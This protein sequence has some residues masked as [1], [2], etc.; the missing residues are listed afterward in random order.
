MALVSR[1]S[2]FAASLAVA[3]LFVLLWQAVST[4][5]LVSPLFLPSPNR[6]Y[7]ALVRGLVQGPALAATLETVQ[8]MFYGWLVASLLGIGIGAAIG[9]SER[10]R[11][12]LSPLLEALRPLPASALFPIVIALFGLSEPTF[13]L[14]I[15]FGAVWPMLL[16][17]AHG[18]ATVEPTLRDVARALNMT[19][20]DVVRKIALP[21]AVPE[22]VAAMRLG[23]TIALILAVVGEM[24]TGCPGLGRWL[25]A[26]ARAYRSAD[27]FAGVVL[28]G[29]I[30]Y[31]SSTLLGLAE[32]RLLRW[33]AQVR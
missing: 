20:A 7:A 27:L 19:R 6:T 12:Y 13:L 23:L 17:T 29:A 14:V 33:R 25:L 4:S 9:V 11:A 30:G 31:A 10:S 15:G 5:G 28:L 24:L 3:G 26:S 1:L 21:G 18:V 16:A 32:A 22:I 2:G 8:R